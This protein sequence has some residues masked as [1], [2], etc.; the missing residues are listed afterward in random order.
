MGLLS[1][2]GGRCWGLKPRKPYYH[3]RGLV[4]REDHQGDHGA[5]SNLSQCLSSSGLPR[6]G[7]G[8]EPSCQC[9]RRKRSRSDSWVA[10]IP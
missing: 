6:W 3:V 10:K 8:K 5:L 7:D 4:D 2:G 9:R 1:K